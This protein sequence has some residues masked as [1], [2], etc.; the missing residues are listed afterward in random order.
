M[1]L[2]SG[3][4]SDSALSIFTASLETLHTRKSTF[5]FATHFHEIQNFA[6]IEG[7]E[8]LE[9]KHM[10]VTYNRE[11]DTLVYDR[12]LKEGPGDSMYGLEVCKALH[13]PDDFFIASS[14]D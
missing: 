11:T 10:E 7:L 8:N 1:K 6:E 3:T 14:F 2:C 12:K 13:L 4:E 5:L 9:S